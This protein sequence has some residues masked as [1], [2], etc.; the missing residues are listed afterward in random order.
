MGVVVRAALLL[1]VA[2]LALGPMQE[3]DLFFR[4]QVGEETLRAGSIPGRNLFSFTYPDHPDRDPAWLFGVAAARLF[5]AGGFRALVLANAR[6]ASF[7]AAAA[8]ER[9]AQLSR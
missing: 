3:S 6:S 9:I 2:G 4:L 7:D 5:G 1:F 8:Q